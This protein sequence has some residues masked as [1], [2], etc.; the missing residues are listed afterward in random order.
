MKT[1]YLG[2]LVL[3][4]VACSGGQT[5]GGHGEQSTLELKRAAAEAH[6]KGQ[7]PNG[8]VCA[9]N[10]WYGDGEC[11]T[12]CQDAD[13]TD[14]VV[15]PDPGP[16]CAAFIELSD[17]VCSRPIDDPCRGQ[18]PDCTDVPP[19]C[20]GIPLIAYPSDGV[21]DPADPCSTDWDPDCSV[22]PDPP[23]CGYLIEGPLP[24]DG[25]CMVDPNNPCAEIEDPDCRDEPPVCPPAASAPGIAAPAFPFDGVCHVDPNDPCVEMNDPDC[26]AGPTIDC[27]EQPGFQQPANGVCNTDPSNICVALNDPDCRRVLPAP[28][29]QGCLL[30]AEYPDGVCSRD[31]NDPCISQDPDCIAK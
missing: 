8:D 19:Q 24:R 21:C 18:D 11:D 20:E 22:E 12:F 15:D 31:A 14:C 4:M 23:H 10:G 28:P 13:T 25:V 30:I 3:L 2:G 16:V 7:K 29:E 26:H 5:T 1:K 17:G 6:A 27:R 9:T